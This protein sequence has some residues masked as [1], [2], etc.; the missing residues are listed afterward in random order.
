MAYTDLLENEGS[1]T[2][3][4]AVIKPRRIIT[5]TWSLVSGTIYSATFSFGQITALLDDGT[6][7]D[8]ATSSSLSDGDWFFDVDSSLIYVDI[9]ADPTSSQMVA[10]YELYFG[11]EDAHFFRDPT[12]NT[13]RQV[14]YEPLIV[15]SPDVRQL[16][17]DYLFGVQPTTSSEIVISNATQY[18]QEHLYASSFNRAEIKLYHAIDFPLETGNIK[19]VFSG[20]CGSPSDKDSEVTIRVY[21]ETFELDQDFRLKESTSFY[22]ESAFAELDPAFRNRPIR[23]VYGVVD[24]FIPVNVDYQDESP[25]TSDNRVYRCLHYPF[26]TDSDPN[27]GSIEA[28]VSASP[29]STTTRT[30]VDD[31]DGLRVGDAVWI[32][33][34][35]GPGSDEY[36]IITAVNKTGSHYIDHTTVT[37]PAASGSIVKRSYIGRLD[38]FVDGVAYEARLERDYTESIDLTNDVAGFAFNSNFE[39]NLGIP[40]T[41]EVTDILHCRVYGHKNNV[42]LGGGSFGGDSEETGNLTQGI[43]IL[44]DIFT[45]HL[46][47]PESR[48]DTAT[49][50]SLQASIG[51]EFSFAIPDLSLD[52]FP[53][54]KEILAQIAQ[55]L[56]IRIFRDEDGKWT[57]SPTSDIAS[58]QQTM[59]DEETLDGSYRFDYLYE[60]IYSDIFVEYN[61]REVSPKN[62]ISEPFFSAVFASSDV[63]S[64]L[65]QIKR[66]K[67]FR[68]YHLLESEAQSL[69]DRLAIILG[70]RRGLV[71]LTGKN[72]LFDTELSDAVELSRTRLP[73]YVFDKDT[74]RTRDHRVLSFNK[75]LNGVLLEMD[76]QKAISENSGSF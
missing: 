63:A 13:T 23:K 26:A 53:N 50:A 59:T 29:S 71:S 8:E 22:T 74:E 10:T 2:Q 16:S 75:T 57:I 12:D 68:S 25:T 36:P 47:I 9:G 44:A 43:V 76:D 65:H 52:N 72:K 55:S 1:R 18:L 56:L 64:N 58:T 60:D 70:D 61:L 32:D 41:L 5:E 73:G 51:D 69:V 20:L 39:S 33:S 21:D 28:T 42:S 17:S 66:Q 49:F 19:E 62:T 48:I 40:R 46:A 37:T 14:Y 54:T 27:R 3:Y 6:E 7:L 4:L 34:S 35:S 30:Y 24:G 67:T 15:R 45:N 31:A 38:V 11:T